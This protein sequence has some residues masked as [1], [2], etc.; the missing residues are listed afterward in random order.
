MVKKVIYLIFFVLC[1]NYVQA[2]ED[3]TTAVIVGGYVQNA[4]PVVQVRSNGDTVDSA[5]IPNSYFTTAVS[6]ANT[7]AVTF[8]ASIWQ[9]TVDN[10][11]WYEIVGL[12]GELPVFANQTI[13]TDVNIPISGII[14]RSDTVATMNVY[15]IRR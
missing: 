7:T 12:G 10:D 1:F 2:I 15:G 4:Q 9:F 5:W 14:F 13:N 6:S 3:V 8:Q 11:G